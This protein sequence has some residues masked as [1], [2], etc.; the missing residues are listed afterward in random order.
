MRY[1]NVGGIRDPVKQEIALE[2]CRSQNKDIRILA[3]T[4]IGQEQI[5]KI[6]NNWLGPIYCILIK[7][8]ANNTKINHKMIYFSDHCNTIY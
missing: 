1:A 8:I 7:K 4:D 6:R 5:H 2:F 3:E